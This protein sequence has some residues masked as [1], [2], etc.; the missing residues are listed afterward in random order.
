MSPLSNAFLTVEQL[1]QME[2]Y[3]PL[4]AYVC[5]SCF[6]VQLPEVETPQHIFAK[7]YAYF[8]SYSQTWLDHARTY[9]DRMIERFGY[10]PASLVVEIASNDG[11][12]LQYFQRKNVPVLGIEPAENCAQ[13]AQKAGIPTLMR[14]FGSVLAA[15][16]KVQGKSADLVVGNNVLAHVPSLNDFVRGLKILLNPHGIIT[17]EFPHLLK[18][19]RENEFDTIYHEHY[20]YFSLYTVEQVFARQGLKLFDVEQLPT[21]GGSL[22]IYGAHAEDASK[23]LTG[24]V[25]QLREEEIQSGM[26]DLKTYLGFSEQVKR[27]KRKL[28]EFLIHAKGAGKTIVA[29]GAPAKGNTLLNYCGV[30]T[31]F[32]DYAVDR[33]PYKQGRFLPGTRIPVFHP[34]RIRDTRPDY[35]LVLP[36]NIKEE[37]MAQMTH[38]REWNAKFVIPIPEVRAVP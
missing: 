38:I 5:D 35:V 30:G 20:S 29:Y 6:L 14:F 26:A 23:A 32:I 37:V 33:S 17:M 3:Y 22:R 18:L 36:W 15:E 25:T 4:H 9:T 28:L 16:L 11:Y 27:T 1:Q 7:D 31:D 13:V 24:K 21:H 10:G 34:D 19:M 8:S 2:P 12:L